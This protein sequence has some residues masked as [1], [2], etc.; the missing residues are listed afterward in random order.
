MPK[1]LTNLDI[2][3]VRTFATIARLGSFTHIVRSL[4]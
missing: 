2:D 3:L 1:T 4:G